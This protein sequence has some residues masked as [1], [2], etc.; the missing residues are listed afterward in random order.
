VEL[1]KRREFF[2]PRAPRKEVYEFSKEF[3]GALPADYGHTLIMHAKEF[4][5]EVK[6]DE[7]LPVDKRRLLTKGT[8]AYWDAKRSVWPTLAK[9]AL[10]C[11]IARLR[12]MGTPQRSRMSQEH[13]TRELRFR[14]NKVV[15]SKL[16]AA[17][18]AVMMK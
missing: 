5:A 12:V 16:L 11:A 15:L 7:A 18:L 17:S 13:V 2:M 1:L 14:V 9:I 3:L 10:Y 4:V 8:Y 6:A